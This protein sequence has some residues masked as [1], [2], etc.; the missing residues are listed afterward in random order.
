MK[1]RGSYGQA[2]NDRIDDQ[3]WRTAF[4]VGTDKAYYLNE[5]PLTFFYPNPDNIPNP[6]LKWETAITRNLGFDMGFLKN[7]LT[8]NIDIYKNTGKELLL[9]SDVPPETGYTQQMTNIGATSN[10]GIEFVI[11]AIPIQKNDFQVSFNFN[12]SF[13]KNRV[14]D[15]GKDNF[16]LYSSDWNSDVGADYFVKVGEPV[17]QMYGFITD[18]FYKVDDFQVDAITGKLMKDSKGIYMLK[19][20]IADNSGILYAGFGPGAVKFKNLGDPLDADGNPV[21]DGN[22]VTFDADRTVIGNANPK[23]V[24]GVNMSVMYKGFDASIF[25]NW[26]FGNDIYNANKIE[27]TSAYRK[28]TNLLTEMSSDKRWTNIND[29]GAVITDAAE[30]AERNKNATIWSPNLGRYLF[31]SWAVEDGSFLRISNLTIG[32]TLPA[33]WTRKVFIQNLRV[34][35]TGNNLLTFTKYSGFD[36]EVDT[37]RSTPLTPGVD[38]SAYP[39]SKMYL[40]GLNVTF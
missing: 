6:Y 23:H 33:A 3:L 11:D 7:R 24:G 27:F 15:L 30:L 4:S 26:V 10:Q 14:E 37:R 18:G 1:I 40:V 13:N 29:Q 12:I 20:G 35:A 34:Y 8:A 2:G 5:V 39:R 21:P 38:Y 36:P 16:F 31:H 32:Y 19:P 25:M 9:Q 28:Y 22:K 17:G